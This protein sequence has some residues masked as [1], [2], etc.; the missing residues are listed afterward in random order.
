MRALD[1]PA[2]Q[3][4][5]DEVARD[6]PLSIPDMVDIVRET[7]AIYLDSHLDLASRPVRVHRAEPLFAG[8]MVIAVD[9]QVFHLT[10]TEAL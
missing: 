1:R 4:P 3:P 6:A 7:L 5:A 2:I 10:V 9:D 8:M